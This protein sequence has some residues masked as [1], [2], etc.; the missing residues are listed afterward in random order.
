MEEIQPLLKQHW[1]EAGIEK[2]VS[3][4]DPDWQQSFALEAAG[5]LGIVT[6]RVNGK[7]GGY[8][9][10]LV[11]PTMQNKSTIWGQIDGLWLHPKLR[12]G[13]LGNK[14]LQFA[15]DKLR[16]AGAKIIK[17]DTAPRVGNWLVRRGYTAQHVVLTKVLED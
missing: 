11:G 10:C 6:L 7:L 17:I 1:A 4:F 8:V 16:A 2:E 3:P 9:V 14:L 12:R 5:V 15:E 13:N